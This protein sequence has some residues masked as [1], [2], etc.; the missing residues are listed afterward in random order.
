MYADR[1]HHARETCQS[2]RPPQPYIRFATPGR[3]RG[4]RSDQQAEPATNDADYR[5]TPG[6]HPYPI[7]FLIPVV[8]RPVSKDSATASTHLRLPVPDVESSPPVDERCRNA[9][10]TLHAEHRARSESKAPTL[11]RLAGLPASDAMESSSPL[12]DTRSTS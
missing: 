8:S 4:S 12:R 10:R 7:V 2:R 6:S 11:L 3:C 5:E 9:E 1:E